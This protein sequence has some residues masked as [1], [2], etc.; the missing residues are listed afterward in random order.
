MYGSVNALF[1]GLALAGVIVAVFLQS[2]ELKLQREELELTRR[3]LARSAAAQTDQVDSMYLSGKLSALPIMIEQNK[4]RL[5]KSGHPK[6][7]KVTVEM[8]T[9]SWIEAK[10]GTSE[11]FISQTDS[12]RESLASLTE[13]FEKN[14]GQSA[15]EIAKYHDWLN[16]LDELDRERILHFRALP[17]LKSLFQYVTELENV[18]STI[19]EK[20]IQ[21]AT[22]ADP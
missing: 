4:E 10:I 17:I 21:Y 15:S 13:E 3:E 16:E 8:L 19:A 9:P 20:R 2:R 7:Q 12:K 18:F 22:P 1:S 5:K 14:E 6:F 11:R